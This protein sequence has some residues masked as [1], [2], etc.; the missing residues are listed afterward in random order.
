MYKRQPK[1]HVI[2]QEAKLRMGLTTP[3][4]EHAKQGTSEKAALESIARSNKSREKLKLAPAVLGVKKPSPGMEA[5][6][7]DKEK[8][9]PK[10]PKK[11]PNA[12]AVN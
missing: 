3:E 2:V 9:P 7:N 12:N 10:K 1:D 8:T 5:K 6:E 4:W 11:S